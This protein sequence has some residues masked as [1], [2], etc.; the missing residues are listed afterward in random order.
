M[1][2]WIL[3]VALTLAVI[4]LGTHIAA[5]AFVVS[6]IILGGRAKQKQWSQRG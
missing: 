1:P 6:R 5:V 2:P 4:V 3:I